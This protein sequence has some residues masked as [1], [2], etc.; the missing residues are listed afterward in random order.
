MNVT[1]TVPNGAGGMLT[2]TYH[3][4]AN[5]LF[6]LDSL[7]VGQHDLNIIYAPLNDTLVRAI[8]VLP[9]QQTSS[10]AIYKFASN[11]FSSSGGG[12]CGSS[13]VIL[14]PNG[15]GSMTNL[16]RSG[17]SANWQCV[18]EAVADDDGSYVQRADNSYAPEVYAME[19]PTSSAC[20]ITRV[21]VYCRAR[22]TQ[23]QGDI[24]PSLYI[25]GTEYNGTAQAL[26]SSYANYSSQWTTNPSTGAAWT[27]TEVNSLQAGMRIRGQSGTHPAR[28]TQVWV[29]VRY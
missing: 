7:P 6:Q 24:R 15:A 11:H 13:T 1:V 18:S 5:G 19:N 29:E 28:C 23:S 22:R 26:S 16:T 2:K 25:G 14:R 20:A 17:C 9:R 21:T 3:P 8:T 27:W 10:P 12:G 4:L